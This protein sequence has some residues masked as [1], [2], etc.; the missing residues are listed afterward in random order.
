MILSQLLYYTLFIIT[1][2]ITGS[3]TIGLRTRQRIIYGRQT[4]YSTEYL[5]YHRI[6][7][8]NSLLH[9]SPLEFSM[10]K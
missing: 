4:Q 9:H 8:M 3:T 2:T 10:Q 1:T 5:G 6:T 7:R